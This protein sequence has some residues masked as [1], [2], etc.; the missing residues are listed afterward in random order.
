L[1]RLGSFNKLSFVESPCGPNVRHRLIFRPNHAFTIRRK[2]RHAQ[3]DQSVARQY[4]NSGL[5]T[6][7]TVHAAYCPIQLRGRGTRHLYLETSSVSKQWRPVYCIYLQLILSWQLKFEAAQRCGLV[8]SDIF[9]A[10]SCFL[11]CCLVFTIIPPSVPKDPIY[12]K[13]LSFACMRT[14][15]CKFSRLLKNLL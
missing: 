7:S 8:L 4:Q 14:L 10:Y 6:A 2:T 3:P 11:N 9:R 5:C 15:L 13:T 12:Q 1:V